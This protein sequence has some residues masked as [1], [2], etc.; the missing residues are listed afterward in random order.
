[1]N[2][3][4]TSRQFRHSF[5]RQVVAPLI[6]ILGL[7][8][9][10]AG[11]GL[12]WGTSVT[13]SEAR[14]QQQRMISASFDQSLSEHLRQ[15]RSLTRWS[16]LAGHLT[17]GDA[18][19][20]WLDQNVGSWLYEMF[21]HQL[22]LLLDSRQQ[23]VAVWRNGEPVSPQ[24]VGPWLRNL[25]ATPLVTRA[26]G[27]ED[28]ADFVRIAGR[29]AALAVGRISAPDSTTRFSLVSV[30]FLDDGYL[31]HLS[32]LIRRARSGHFHRRVASG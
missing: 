1:M 32:E 31:R 3:I 24:A 30:A 11:S 17:R 23:P 18:D 15:L 4:R 13:N 16:P 10:G 27:A 29:A 25:L 5:L 9:A 8:F 22:I 6:A 20:A 21:A 26:A 12:Y 7:S 14:E 19:Q 28:R 2:S